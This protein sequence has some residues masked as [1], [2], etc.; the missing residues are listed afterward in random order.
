MVVE[1]VGRGAGEERFRR[2]VRRLTVVVLVLTFGQFFLWPQ[3]DAHRSVAGF[4]GACSWT[5]ALI[6]LASMMIAG[7]SR[8][9]GATGDAR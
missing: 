9:P 5:L 3:H 7:P 1:V 2:V 4:V 6:V 8:D